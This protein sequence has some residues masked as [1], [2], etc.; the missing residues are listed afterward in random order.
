MIRHTSRKLLQLAV[1]S[2]AFQ[3]LLI[4]GWPLGFLM[5]QRVG[6]PREQASYCSIKRRERPSGHNGLERHSVLSSCNVD[7]M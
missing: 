5:Q 4:K 1:P 2:I 6:I 3:P 7:S